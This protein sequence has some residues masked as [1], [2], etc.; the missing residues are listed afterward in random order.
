MT[1]DVARHV[2][3]KGLRFLRAVEYYGGEASMTDIR[4]RTGL[5]RDAANYRFRRLEELGLISVTYADQGFGERS[6]PKVA[7][8]TG[9]ARRAIERG[10]FSPLRDERSSEGATV[11]LQAEVRAIR[12]RIDQHKRR[13]DTVTAAQPTVDQLEERLDAVEEHLDDLEAYTC[14]WNEAAELYLR[15]L[16]AALEDDGID[17]SEYLREAQRR[18]K[19]A[20]LS[21]SGGPQVAPA[22]VHLFPVVQPHPVQYFIA[23]VAGLVA[24]VILEDFD[25]LRATT[26]IRFEIGVSF[27]EDVHT[28]AVARDEPLHQSSASTSASLSPYPRT[29]S[30]WG[31]TRPIPGPQS[32]R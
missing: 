24:R 20:C 15:G 25:H 31:P 11:G 14:D 12:E 3:T 28:N 17:V 2:D 1:S 10:L 30:F 23:L 26:V 8:L 22:E 5:S 16:R 29:S 21:A 19:P 27:V 4:Q 18:I 13:L 9:T 6:P 7:H 32:V